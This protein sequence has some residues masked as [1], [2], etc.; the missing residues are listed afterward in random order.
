MSIVSLEF[1]AFVVI[2]AIIYFLLP[3]KAQWIFLLAVSGLFFCLNSS[4]IQV[5]SLIVFLAINFIFSLIMCKQT[6]R[7]KL[8]FVCVIVFDVTYLLLLKYFS[9]FSPILSAFSVSEEYLLQMNEV[10]MGI[11]PTG[12]SY[13]ALIVIGYMTEIYWE[14]VEVQ[15]NPGKFVLFA[16]YFPHIISGPIVKY[17][18]YDNNL[19]GEKHEFCYDRVISGIER[20]IFGAFKKLVISS[21]A[22]IVANTIYDSYHVYTG[23]YVPLGIVFYIIQL[24]CDF[25]GL[26]DIVIGVSE[27]F[28]ISLPENFNTPFYSESMSEFWRRWHITLGRF[29][30]EYVLFPMQTSGWYRKLRKS[31]KK[32]VGKD[33]EK[34]FN[35]PR[36]FAMLISWILIG[37]WHGGGL[38]YVWGVGIYMWLVIILGESL[39]PLFKKAIVILNIN[40]ECFSWKLFRRCRTFI[41]YMF[42]VSFFRAKTLKDG[43]MLWKNAFSKFNPWIFVDKSIYGLGLSREEMTILVFSLL[44]LFIVSHVKQRGSVR[45]ALNR[46]NYFFRVFVYIALISMTVIWGYY[47]PGFDA[48]DFIYGKF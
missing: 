29:L 41:L 40:T 19:W 45:E 24:Y 38:N 31:Y 11:A 13:I 44:I 2:T 3:G 7:R 34:K 15:K 35:A 12:I 14:H 39:E 33:F 42:G 48:A 46:Q 6:D 8:V 16:C 22:A 36:Y 25:S 32:A 4:V 17:Q 20:I 18:E 9:F 21:R 10:L 47:G 28:G 26:M 5:I 1:L 30:K 23:F 43:F 27:I 37:F